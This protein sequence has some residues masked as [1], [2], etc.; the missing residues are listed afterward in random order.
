MQPNLFTMPPQSTPAIYKRYLVRLMSFLDDEDYAIDHE[1]TNQ[2]LGQLTPADL[3]RWFNRETF[4][5][6]NPPLGHNLD[7]IVR[8]S[9]IA[10]WKKAISYY[11]PNKITPWN[12]LA[13]QG[14]PTRSIEV[15]QLYKYVK[16][17]EVRRQGVAS[18]ADM[19]LQAREYQQMM[20]ILKTES[21]GDD[22]LRKYGIPA[23]INYQFHMLA[24]VDDVSQ[25]LREN[26]QLHDRFPNIALKSRINWSKNVMEERDAPFQSMLASMDPVYCV[27]LSLSLWLE[28]HAEQNPNAAL[29]PFLF[30][31]SDDNNIPSGGLKSK[32]TVQGILRQI[33]QRRDEFGP[34]LGGH[35]IRKYAST[36]CRRKGATRDEKDIRGRWKSRKRVS[37]RYDDVELPYPDTKV[38]ALL[39]VGGPCRYAVRENCGI[40]N[41]W[42]LEHVVPHARLLIGDNAATVLGFSLLWYAFTLEGAT[43]MP[44]HLLQRIRTAYNQLNNGLPEGMNPVKKIPVIINGHEGEVYID[45]IPQD[46]VDVGGNNNNNNIAPQNNNAIVGAFADRPVRTQLLALHSQLMQVRRAQDELRQEIKEIHQQQQRQ[47]NTIN[48]N[49][50]RIAIAPFARFPRQQAGNQQAANQQAANQQAENQQQAGNMHASLSPTPRCLWTLWTEYLVGI[51]GRKPASQ[52]TAVERGRVKFKYSR[53]KVVW[54]TISRLMRAGLTSDTAIDRIYAAYGPDQSVT[55]IINQMLHDRRHGTVP[56]ALL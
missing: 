45:D 2:R 33:F 12:Q 40:S 7:P 38:A 29:S 3:M 56:A 50:R 32:A 35:S 31:F 15:N 5:V 18:K 30:A 39:C 28:L 20:T 37:D 19:P 14:N 43:G 54:D 34:H 27:H 4:G 41:A 53:R 51:G 6:E 55:E 10:V 21:A 25:S 49:I 9:S 47:F 52:F 24:R 16:K 46:D 42:I 1:F 36:D 48:S 17:K 13:Q 11:M 23:F 22:I 44:A 26:L 8:S